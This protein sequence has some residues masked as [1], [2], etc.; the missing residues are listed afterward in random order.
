MQRV[1]DLGRRVGADA[2]EP[3]Q[4]PDTD[5]SEIRNRADVLREKARS[6][7]AYTG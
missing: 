7:L 4:I 6:M 3:E 1:G 2:G 5:S